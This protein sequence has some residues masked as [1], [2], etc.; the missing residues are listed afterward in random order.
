MYIFVSFANEDSLT[1][2]FSFWQFSTTFICLF[3]LAKTWSTILNRY[4]FS[5][6]L[7]LVHDFSEIALNF[8]PFN[9]MFAIGVCETPLLCWSVPYIPNLYWTSFMKIHW[10]LEQAFSACNEMTMGILSFYL[11]KWQ[12]TF[13]YFG[14]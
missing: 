4:G 12:I 9:W 6:Q 14:I 5:G 1:S 8:S 13:I 10:N 3:A 7:C 2:S 11:F